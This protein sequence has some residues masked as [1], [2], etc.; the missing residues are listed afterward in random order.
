MEF[1]Q[2]KLFFKFNCIYYFIHSLFFYSCFEDIAYSICCP[3]CVVYQ[4]HLQTKK[5]GKPNIPEIGIEFNTKKWKYPEPVAGSECCKDCLF[6]TVSYVF[7][8]DYY[9]FNF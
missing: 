4:A 3:H 1:K 8:H 6:A 5:V 2:R 7:L 9:S